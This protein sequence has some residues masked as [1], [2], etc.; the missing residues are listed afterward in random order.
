MKVQKAVRRE[1]EKVALGVAIMTA[2]MLGILFA[3]HLVFP[4]KL[5]FSLGTVVSALLGAAVSV[6]NFFLMG[7]TV[8][9]VAGLEDPKE[10]KA[11]HAEILCESQ[12]HADCVDDC[13]GCRALRS[14]D[15][16]YTAPV[17]SGPFR[18]LARFFPEKEETEA[19]QGG[20]I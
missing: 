17:L 18:A 3:L 10:A 20:E 11:F 7:L 13:R 6:L 4:G 2:L 16:G 19:K 5:G 1:T 14:P 9:H 8:Q 15:C 12:Y